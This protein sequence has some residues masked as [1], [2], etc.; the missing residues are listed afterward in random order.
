MHICFCFARIVLYQVF[1]HYLIK[2]QLDQ[3]ATRHERGYATTC[4]VVAKKVIKVSVEHQRKGLLC[5]TSWPSVYTIF[6][7]IV[8]LIFAHATREEHTEDEETRKDIE[9][10]LRLL[11]STACTTDTGSIRCLE[12][13]RRLLSRVSHRT[14]IE[15]D[16]I[17]TSTRLACVID[18]AS[19]GQDNTS[20]DLDKSRT[21]KLSTPGASQIPPVP[22]SLSSVE[23]DGHQW[24]ISPAIT[25]TQPLCSQ[26]QYIH[27]PPEQQLLRT[28]DDQ[29]LDVLHGGMFDWHGPENNDVF[30]FDK[31]QPTSHQ[32]TLRQQ[33][34][35]PPHG[36]VQLTA[37][38]ILVF[39][40]SSPLEK[41]LSAKGQ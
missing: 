23:P 31:K 36:G 25:T 17:Y 22:L 21:T 18:P 1:L 15:F 40:H 28:A 3:S 35:V 6:I 30:I 13:L 29:M 16:E 41:H 19:Q 4:I 12:V 38:D 27:Q 24:W 9:D 10:G 2:P 14:K 39:M 33:R 34:D 8:C 5:P 11:A 32:R 37:E 7:S 26:T 20:I